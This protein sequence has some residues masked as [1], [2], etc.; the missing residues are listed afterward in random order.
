MRIE[1][2]DVLL[3]LAETGRTRGGLGQV[4][5]DAGQR[6][7][8]E[9]VATAP[10]RGNDVLDLRFFVRELLGCEAILAAV[11]GSV[12]NLRVARV[13]WAIARDHAVPLRRVL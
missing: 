5:A 6:E 10:R 11:S 3:T 7:V 13:A 4:A 9:R 12:G 1:E 2:L 8:I